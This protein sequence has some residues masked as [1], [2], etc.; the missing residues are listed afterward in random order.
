MLPPDVDNYLSEISRVL[1]QGGRCLTTFFLLND[2]SEALISR[3]HSK[4][5]FR[6]ELGRCLTID[7]TN[8]E[9]AIAY[10]EEVVVGLLR[11]HRL[12]ITGPIHYGSWCDRRHFLSYQD[13][14][15]TTKERSLADAA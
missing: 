2:E 15:I 10:N 8:P 14:L 1:K 3:G 12:K 13:I 9:S 11:K 5:D 4:L 6:Y 7:I